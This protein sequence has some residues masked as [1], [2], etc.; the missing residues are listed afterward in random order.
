VGLVLDVLESIDG[1]CRDGKLDSTCW[2]LEG[3]KNVGTMGRTTA[4]GLMILTP[5]VLEGIVVEK[6]RLELGTSVEVAWL[7]ER[8][9]LELSESRPVVRATD[10]RWL[11]NAAGSS[12][13]ARV[14][15]ITRSCSKSMLFTG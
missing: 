7:V 14:F 2:E 12:A 4:L 13:E 11:G 6:A 9:L 1:C 10:N 5:F 8:E 3:E 15:S